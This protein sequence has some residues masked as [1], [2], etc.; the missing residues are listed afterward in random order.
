M[1]DYVSLSFSFIWFLR[2]IFVITLS[3]LFFLCIFLL[4]H[5]ASLFF[6]GAYSEFIIVI[7]Q[8]IKRTILH[9]QHDGGDLK[10]D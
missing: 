8:N 2:L 1:R 7:L 6:C 10:G 3:W 4:F 5:F 9:I